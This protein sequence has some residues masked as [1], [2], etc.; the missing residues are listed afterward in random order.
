VSRAR[1]RRVSGFGPHH[2]RQPVRATDACRRC[3]ALHGQT[4]PILVHLPAHQRLCT[5]HRI[6][7]GTTTQ[8]DI[9]ATPEILHAH[10]RAA[11]LAYRYGDHASCSPN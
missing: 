5:R 1:P 9:G 7:L 11:R 10:H 6:W 8:I 2:G 4:G 3:A